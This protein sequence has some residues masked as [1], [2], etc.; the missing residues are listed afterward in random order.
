MGASTATVDASEQ[1]AGTCRGAGH[2]PNSAAGRRNPTWDG[3][4][5]PPDAPAIDERPRPALA[6]GAAATG[7]RHLQD[8]A[9]W[10]TGFLLFGPRASAQLVVATRPCACRAPCS[11]PRHLPWLH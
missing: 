1:P 7:A 2:G 5:G 6:V 10:L 4:P 3:G 9:A 8:G 11:E